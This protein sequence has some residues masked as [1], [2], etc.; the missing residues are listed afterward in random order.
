MAFLWLGST[1][2][3]QNLET[4][5]TLDRT[6]NSVSAVMKNAGCDLGW[7]SAVV[8]DSGINPSDLRHLPVGQPVKIKEGRCK[9]APPALVNDLSSLLLRLDSLPELSQELQKEYR[10]IQKS[11]SA[12]LAENS[13]AQN[14]RKTLEEK[15]SNLEQRLS[16]SRTG[17]RTQANLDASTWRM[18]GMGT[19][20]GVALTLLLTIPFVRKARKQSITSVKTDEVD[21][22]TF[23]SPWVLKEKDRP[24]SFKFVGASP[25]PETGEM[26]GRYMCPLCSEKNL[27]GREFNLRQ[28]LAKKHAGELSDHVA[29]TPLHDTRKV[30]T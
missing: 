16:Q 10:A 14:A 19:M 20:A 1:A 5:G 11:A 23:P 7:L 27:F 21:T 3:A 17:A 26:L 8:E 24:Y 25:H 12:L 18:I 15:S 22:I 29:H 6:R 30:T 2:S 9:T 28:H 4:L 13:L